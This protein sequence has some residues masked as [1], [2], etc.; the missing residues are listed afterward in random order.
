MPNISLQQYLDHEA[1]ISKNKP[2][3]ATSAPAERETGDGGLHEQIMD[4]CD[5]QWPRWKYI[6]ART[7]Q[8]STIAVG[9]P[10]FVIFLPKG[11]VM[12]MECKAKGGKATPEQLAWQMELERLETTLYFVWSFEDFISVLR[13]KNLAAKNPSRPTTAERGE[14][15]PSM[16]PIGGQPTFQSAP[17]QEEN[18]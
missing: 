13:D 12:A 2:Q 17:R 8:K 11:E 5:Q 16:K 6:H 18:Y 10:D 3:A 1:R 9:A 15:E 14:P 7:D 4:Y